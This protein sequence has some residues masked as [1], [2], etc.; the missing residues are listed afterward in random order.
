MLTEAERAFPNETG[1]VLIGYWVKFYEEAVIT[2]VT[3]PGPKAVHCPRSFFPDSEYQETEI[4][5]HY[6]TSGRLHT[7]LGDWHTHPKAAAYLSGTDKK[8]M[9]RIASHSEARAPIPLMAVLGEGPDWILKIW[10][11]FPSKYGRFS[12]SIKMASLKVQVYL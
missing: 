2:H 11:Y 4:T 7:Y 1:G 10:K 5:N 6:H 8:T 3:G 12:F 9:R